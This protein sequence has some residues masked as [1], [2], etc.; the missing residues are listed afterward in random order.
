VVRENGLT[1]HDLDGSDG[2]VFGEE[3]SQTLF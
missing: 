1:P 3:Q 2:A